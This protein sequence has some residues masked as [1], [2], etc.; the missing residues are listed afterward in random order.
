MAHKKPIAT[1]LV[2]PSTLSREL[3]EYVK[4]GNPLIV[5]RTKDP[6]TGRMKGKDGR[7]IWDGKD[8]IFFPEKEK[9]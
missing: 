3:Q 9:F 5:V 1:E 8:F 2:N 4:A 7:I 6:K